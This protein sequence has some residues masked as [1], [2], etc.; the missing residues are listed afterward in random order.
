MLIF[1]DEMI[2]LK[3]VLLSSALIGFP[4]GWNPGHEYPLP[5]APNGHKGLIPVAVGPG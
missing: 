5:V 3:F 1:Q 2:H 4:T